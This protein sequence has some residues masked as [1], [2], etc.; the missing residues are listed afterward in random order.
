[1]SDIKKLVND[2]VYKGTK[3]IWFDP[4]NYEIKEASNNYFYSPFFSGYVGDIDIPFKVRLPLSLI[5]K[6][7]KITAILGSETGYITIQPG[8]DINYDIRIDIQNEE[9]EYIL[10]Y[11]YTQSLTKKTDTA[12]ILKTYNA[13][14]FINLLKYI[15]I[16]P[17]NEAFINDE[18]RKAFSRV[19]SSDSKLSW[20]YENAYP[21]AIKDREDEQLWNDLL[22]ISQYDGSRWFV[23]TGS[24]VMNIAQNF[25]DIKWIIDKL[26]TNQETLLEV[27]NTI[28][29]YETKY[30]FATMINA[31]LILEGTN[32]HKPVFL[33][34]S[35]YTLDKF[36]PTVENKLFRITN[37]KLVSTRV[38]ASN[39]GAV[40]SQDFATVEDAN[41]NP[42]D[43]VIIEDVDIKA[44]FKKPVKTAPNAAIMLYYMADNENHEELVKILRITFDV[45]AILAVAYSGGTSSV[46]IRF[47]EAGL[48]LT[49]IAMMDEGVRKFLSENGG[50]WFVENWDTI[51]LMAGLGFLSRVII[52]GILTKGPALLES[53]KNIRNIPKNWFLFRKDL[54]KLIKELEAYEAR[55]AALITN[56]IDEVIIKGDRYALW[57]KVL[58]LATSQEKYL[59][60]VVRELQFKGISLKKIAEESYEVFYNGEKLKVGSGQSLG[61]LLQ[62]LYFVSSKNF[63]KVLYSYFISVE[64]SMVFI[65]DVA[66]E[67]TKN[68]LGGHI[69]YMKNLQRDE[70]LIVKLEDVSETSYTALYKGEE[71]ATE[72]SKSPK[73]AFKRLIN[74]T[75]DIWN[76][77]GDILADQMKKLL[78]LVKK[79]K[80]MVNTSAR[81]GE[82]A[83][84]ET[85]Q[86]GT[87]KMKLH[88][89]FDDMMQFLKERDIKIVEIADITQDVG[90]TEK[91]VFTRQLE[92]VRI[93]KIM[94][95][96]PEMRFLDLEHE[97]DHVIQLEKNLQGK[98]ATTTEIIKRPG[99][100]VPQDM[101]KLGYL[102]IVERNFLEYE[103]RVKEVLRLKASGAPKEL[104][105][106]HLEGLKDAYNTFDNSKP[107]YIGDKLKYNEWQKKYFPDFKEFDFNNF[108]Y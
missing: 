14:D 97:I 103:V 31:F 13:F 56:E 70:L 80:T 27:Y 51:Y 102:T 19:E 59:E 62:K 107:N 3:E 34:G 44:S 48:A 89:K 79:S 45:A 77:K 63:E 37:Q 90:Y 17:A 15:N 41:L 22:R 47:I 61:K 68:G 52:N 93:D 105:Q 57:R 67:L 60:Q 2:L 23:D 26:K 71:I 99:V 12:L 85:I 66:K 88:P 104:I 39:M 87:V 96:H 94:E 74:K 43:L 108:T 8:K 4:K 72:I 64:E 36:T 84:S 54:E 98:Y 5:E 11:H 78:L 16:K 76:N 100:E 33:K 55:Q 91:F 106:E 42:C 7:L 49:D 28:S 1:M 75:K 58:N 9:I 18:F 46:L 35:L 29:D 6:E 20:L 95:W 24:A 83:T 101:P 21:S 65:D 92:L 69:Q 82:Q 30:A 32:L 53:L 73:E 38:I 40:T 10:T 50:E 81:I 25:S 86:W